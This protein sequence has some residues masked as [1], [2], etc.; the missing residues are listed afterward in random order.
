MM[1]MHHFDK[2]GILKK[3]MEE[4]LF[5]KMEVTAW[6]VQSRKLK[7]LPLSEGVSWIINNDAFLDSKTSFNDVH[8][9]PSSLPSF[10]S[11]FLILI[12][13]MYWI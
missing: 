5:R 9:L 4:I 6:R 8:I 3:E 1:R 2:N 12:Q 7:W 11:L 10:Y 13:G